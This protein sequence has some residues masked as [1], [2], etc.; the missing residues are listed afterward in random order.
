MQFGDAGAVFDE[1]DLADLFAGLAGRQGQGGRG[2][3][4]ARRGQDYEVTVPITLEEA[5]NGTEISLDH[6]TT[7]FD[8]NGAPRRVEP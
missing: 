5:G 1:M 8:E 6:T 4:R 7:E 2:A 3:P